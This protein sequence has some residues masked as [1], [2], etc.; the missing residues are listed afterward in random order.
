[1]KGLR[2]FF[3]GLLPTSPVPELHD[4]MLGMITWDPRTER[5]WLA[6][7]AAD[8]R[9]GI[10]FERHKREPVP[11]AECLRVARELAADPSVV[12][13]RVRRALVYEAERFPEPRRAAMT[14]LQPTYIVLRVESWNAGRVGGQVALDGAPPLD[15]WSIYFTEG[16]SWWVHQHTEG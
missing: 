3:N 15:H 11:P 8:R 16:A 2:S 9:L 5:W 14:Q 7:R 12:E 10:W 6:P 13:E 1:M 4:P